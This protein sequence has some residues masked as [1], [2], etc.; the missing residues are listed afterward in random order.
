MELL[1]SIVKLWSKYNGVFL[2]GLWGTL[3]LAVVTE[4][5]N[6]GLQDILIAC[7]DGLKD[8][9]EAIAAET[10]NDFV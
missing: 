7:V 1:E 8:L 3:W 4:L 9:P 2:N 6:R 5:K 10:V